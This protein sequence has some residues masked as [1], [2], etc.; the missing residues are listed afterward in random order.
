MLISLSRFSRIHLYSFHVFAKP[1]VVGNCV[2]GDFDFDDVS[3]HVESALEV[4]LFV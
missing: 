2:S 4:T 3:I 1:T